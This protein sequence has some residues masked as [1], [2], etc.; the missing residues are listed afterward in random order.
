MVPAVGNVSRSNRDDSNIA[1]PRRQRHSDAVKES[2]Y[3][4]LQDPPTPSGRLSDRIESLRLRCIE[5][6]GRDAFYDAYNFLKQ[7]EYVS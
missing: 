1:T 5:A 2:P 3:Y 7:T 6:L 4:N